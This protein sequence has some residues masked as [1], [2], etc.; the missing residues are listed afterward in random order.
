MID[1]VVISTVCTCTDVQYL[2]KLFK[3][4]AQNFIHLNYSKFQISKEP[5]TLLVITFYFLS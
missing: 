2:A 4:H 3:S 5:I 1:K